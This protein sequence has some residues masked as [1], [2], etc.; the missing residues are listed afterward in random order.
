MLTVENVKYM[1]Y[2][3]TWGGYE[4]IADIPHHLFMFMEKGSCTYWIEGKRYVVSQGDVLFIGERLAR[5]AEAAV[6]AQSKYSVHWT[7]DG[8]FQHF[9]QLKGQVVVFK[10]AS[11]HTYL[12]QI[13]SQ[14]HH[15]WAKKDMY[16][17]TLCESMLLELAVRIHQEHALRQRSGKQARVVQQ[18]RDYIMEYYREPLSIEELAH[19]VDRN[20]SHVIT[21]FKK[22]YGVAPLE[23]MH[24][25][26]IT[27]AEELLLTSDAKIES[28]AGEL[29]YC[30]AAYFNRM[31][32]KLTG[33]TPSAYRKQLEL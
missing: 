7:G 6:E 18:V 11:L 9:P 24:R 30:D 29:G 10:A 4:P 3:N 28:I 25:T 1:N 5:G 15:I 31:F 2:A 21:S 32:K 20:A 12:K 16:Y 8:L 19:H 27:K 23:Y 26:R 33:M 22:Y 14:M 17:K 13:Y